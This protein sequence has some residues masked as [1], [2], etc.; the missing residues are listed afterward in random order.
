M[1][2]ILVSYFSASGNTKRV[3]E[4]ISKAVSGDLFE[5]EPTVKYS[6]EDLDWTN[7]QSRST[8]EMKD[9]DFRPPIKNKVDN[10]NDYDKVIIGF[11]IWWYTAPTI[12]NT[13][14]EENDLSNKDIY[15]FVTSGGSSVNEGMDDLV[16]EYKN[17]NFVNGKRFV[18]TEEDDEYLSLI[19]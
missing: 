2:K 1:S 5:I 18:G 13:F 17:L 9:R 10:I 11:P 8:I 6:N 12:I 15:I 14:I 16:K 4:R 19:K 3:A 7:N